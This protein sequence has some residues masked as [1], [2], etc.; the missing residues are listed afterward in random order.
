MSE[1]KD[2]NQADRIPSASGVEEYQP[3]Q[4]RL[5][6]T[7]AGTQDMTAE[8]RFARISE[9]SHFIAQTLVSRG[10]IGSFS[11][12]E[13][14]G[15]HIEKP[16]HR[17][18][19][20][21]SIAQTFQ[22]WNFSDWQGSKVFNG[23]FGEKLSNAGTTLLSTTGNLAS[24]ETTV[25]TGES[26]PPELAISFWFYAPNRRFE[27]NPIDKPRDMDRVGLHEPALPRLEQRLAEFALSKDI[28]LPEF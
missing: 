24:L 16:P 11:I 21:K 13:K 1:Y 12:T 17:T 9:M 7:E 8:A 6:I 4:A 23:S 27:F 19:P 18:L 25:L 5:A 15:P 10:D 14:H 20:D 26:I 3:G 2:N 28:T 22:G